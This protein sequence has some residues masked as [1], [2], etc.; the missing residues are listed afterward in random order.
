MTY[1]CIR[2]RC[3]QTLH[4]AK[5]VCIAVISRLVNV[6]NLLVLYILPTLVEDAQHLLQAIIDLS[7]K[8]R[9][10]ND[11]AVVGETVDKW[12]RQPFGNQM[13]IVVVR[14]ATNIKHRLVNVTH[15]MAKQIHC[16]HGDGIGAFM[17]RQH[18]GYV[19][20]LGPQVLTEAQR[21]CFK[22]SLLKFYQNKVSRTVGL[23]NG[24]TE[25]NAEY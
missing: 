23:L 1:L 24:S 16:N 8:K 14:L 21:F 18:V 4:N 19:G 15:L 12:I 3:H 2:S 25:V 22:P 10:L 6:Q 13:A 17:L 20:I 11:N 7:M 9:N 5:H